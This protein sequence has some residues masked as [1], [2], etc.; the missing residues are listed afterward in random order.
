MKRCAFMNTRRRVFKHYHKTLLFMKLTIFLLFVSILEVSASGYGQKINLSE[1]NA[2]LEKVFKEIKKQSGYHFFYEM[3]LVDL[4]KRIDI[5]IH[6]AEIE[7]VLDSCLKDQKLS[8][9]IIEKTIALKRKEEVIL[10]QPIPIPLLE[11]TG[12]VTDGENKPM[13]FVSVVVKGKKI[14]VSTDANGQFTIKVPANSVLRFSYVGYEVKE[15]TV[16]NSENI[17]VTLKA[18]FTAMSDVV[19]IGYGL[20]K[21][22][23]VT[24]AV[25]TVDSKNLVSSAVGNISTALIGN[26]PG[27]SGLQ[28]GGE[29]GRNATTLYI[30]GLSTYNTGAA[31]PLVVIDGVEQAAEQ[32][33]SQLNAM[34]PNEISSI[35]ILKDAASTAVYGIRG[36]NG[37]IIVT[38]K[39]GLKGKQTINVSVSSGYTVAGNL[40]KELSSYDYAVMRNEAINYNINYLG[41]NSFNQ[42][43]FTP[44]ELWKFKNNRDYTPAE[45]SAMSQLTAAQQAQLNA[46]PAIW[47]GSHDQVQ[48]QFGNKGPQTQVNLNIRGGNDKLQYFTSVGYFYQG[49]ILGNQTFGG[50]NT[51]STYTRYNFRSSF[52]FHPTKNLD[53]SLTLAGQFGV[54]NG[55]DGNQTNPQRY[56]TLMQNIGPAC[57]PEAIIDGKLIAGWAGAQGSATN[58]LGLKFN[59]SPQNSMYKLLTSG[60]AV[61]YNSFLSNILKVTHRMDYITKGLSVRA[62]FGYDDNYNKYVTNNASLPSYSITRDLSNPNN[63]V[64]YGGSITYSAL[65]TSAGP[66]AWNKT[67]VDAGIDYNKSIGDHK[68]T[69]LLLGKTSIYRMPSDA[70]NTPSGIMGLVGRVTY[71]YKDRYMAEYD[72]GYNGTEQFAPGKRFGYFP[73]YSLGWVVSNE[74]FLSKSKW[75]DFLKVRG[76]YGEVGSDNL[77]GRRYLYLPN[78]YTQNS[79]SNAY[80]PGTSNGSAINPAYNGTIEGAIG[81]P[82]VT[83]E[84]AK[85]TN[86]GLDAR[87]LNNR[88]SLSIDLFKEQRSD[89]LTTSGIIPVTLGVSAANIPPIN[90]GRTTNQGYE[91]SLGWND[92]INEFHYSINAAISYAKNKIEYMAEAPYPYPWM[93][94]TGYSIGQYKGLRS[95]GFYNTLA[96]LANR[97]YITYSSNVETL[98]N[99]KFKDI[100]GD[101]KVDDQDKVPMGYSNLPQYAFNMK[102]HFDYKGF[103]LG[104]LFNGTANG[105]LYLDPS[106]SGDMFGKQS[107]PAYYYQFDGRWTPE[108]AASGAAINYPRAQINTNAGS[109]YFATT[110]DFWIKSSNFVKI[111]NIELGY[112][113]PSAQLHKWGVGIINSVRF[114]FN[115]NNV[116]TF[117]NALTPFGI[118][119]E[120]IDGGTGTGG[121]GNFFFF[122]PITRAFVFGANVTF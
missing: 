103:D 48:E 100:N 25:S 102:F 7:E 5:K 79:G 76:S 82:N 32:P 20:Q 24:G 78:S 54:T 72:L 121:N 115:G 111:K 41:D 35:S 18:L 73:A 6:N 120:Q 93:N 33:M 110:S 14:G 43:L 36:A 59:N 45:V 22:V 30:R 21:K 29:P 117:K 122:F 34:D 87:F 51:A 4:T 12:K 81:N 11:I 108:K 46:S 23:N 107:G 64:Y 13:P 71:S 105:S 94:A 10:E 92:K 15:V 37:V 52:D 67:Y 101:G 77:N 74:S 106:F 66:S 89:I 50:A 19:V 116:Y 17:T 98:G 56:K 47:Y 1:H 119:P 104:I 118:D 53:I 97:P 99:I 60:Q 65:N 85:K 57:I 40:K 63:I 8:Y 88:L 114:Y 62:T 38:T 16:N 109:D 86:I 49:S 26:A 83:W 91:V 42:Y 95:D 55:F 84:R 70:F 80:Y 68:I 69:A 90:V 28:G 58:P 113:V 44:D 27:I 9:A 96:D 112:T 61:L 39:R 2:P 3:G 75:L 31:N